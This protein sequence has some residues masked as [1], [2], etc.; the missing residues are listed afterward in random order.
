MH[1]L[2]GRA[3]EQSRIAAVRRVLLTSLNFVNLDLILNAMRPFVNLEVSY[4]FSDCALKN[5][6]TSR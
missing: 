2:F 6:V 4:L 3:D 1:N 5:C